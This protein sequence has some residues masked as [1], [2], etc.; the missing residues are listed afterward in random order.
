MFKN[1]IVTYQE[2]DEKYF[3]VYGYQIVNYNPNEELKINTVYILS[4]N[5]FP[6][7]ITNE[8]NNLFMYL[9]VSENGCMNLLKDLVD[10]EF[11]VKILN[12]NNQL[13]Y[14]SKSKKY[15]MTRIIG[16]VIIVLLTIPALFLGNYI[17]KLLNI[18]IDYE[19]QLIIGLVL[20]VIVLILIVK[21]LEYFFGKDK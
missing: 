14:V 13:T 18:N 10:N 1:Y 15:V 7:K 16:T 6:I 20:I 5:Q 4:L 12:K 8:R 3:K 21:L 19:W 2:I 9:I 17:I 11:T